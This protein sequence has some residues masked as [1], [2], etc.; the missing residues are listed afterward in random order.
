MIE[1]ML[2]LACA[3]HAQLALSPEQVDVRAEL[4]RIADYFEGPA[5]QV[6]ATIAVAGA[7]RAH[8]DP[9]LLRRAVANLV[10]NAIRYARPDSII[11][12]DVSEETSATT[13]AVTNE[14]AGIA[15]ED[16]PRIF[17][18]F[19]RADGSRGGT[20]LGWARSRHCQVH[21]GSAWRKRGGSK[22]RWGIDGVLARVSTAG[23]KAGNRRSSI[24]FDGSAARWRLA[25][26]N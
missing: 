17:D 7:G 24:S 12:L 4:E 18:R 23:R 3:D 22:C 10:D 14:G 8:A 26:V 5:D 16:T 13:I 19:Y 6:G 20:I 21:H 11:R 15:S 25:T 1:S 9:V 2:F